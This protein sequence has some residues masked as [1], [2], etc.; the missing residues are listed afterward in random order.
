M[1]EFEKHGLLVQSRFEGADQIVTAS[2]HSRKT[3]V[4]AFSIHLRAIVESMGVG[5][6]SINILVE[7]VT[8]LVRR[9]WANRR[10][11]GHPYRLVNNL[12]FSL[13]KDA[14]R[15]ELYREI[16]GDKSRGQGE[17]QLGQ[18]IDLFRPGAGGANIVASVTPIAAADKGF[19]D[20]KLLFTVIVGSNAKTL[21]IPRDL[22]PFVGKTPGDDTHTVPENDLAPYIEFSY[23]K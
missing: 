15:I 19:A 4:P 17:I 3:I 5:R 23:T 6:H 14:K 10:N 2:A 20:D 11:F 18:G 7:D 9:Q 8:D 16:S 12:C 22:K 21:S 13:E 1:A